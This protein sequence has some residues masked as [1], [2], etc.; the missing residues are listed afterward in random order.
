VSR[1]IKQQGTEPEVG[2]MTVHVDS[3]LRPHTE[4]TRIRRQ[5]LI[6]TDD[7]DELVSEALVFKLTL[8]RLIA[9]ENFIAIFDV[10]M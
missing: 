7:G 10:F 5:P 4:P 2:E 6:D 3:T 8:T 9:R 1:L